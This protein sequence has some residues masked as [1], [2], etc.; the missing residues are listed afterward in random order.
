[1]PCPSGG[2]LPME[3]R[4]ESQQVLSKQQSDQPFTQTS[5]WAPLLFY[6]L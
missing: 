6:S 4:R 1:V 3:K 2:Y 5:M